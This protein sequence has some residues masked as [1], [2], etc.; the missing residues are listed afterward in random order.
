MPCLVILAM[1]P[2]MIHAMSH[3][4][5]ARDP[6]VCSFVC[7]FLC[8]R[9]SSLVCAPARDSMRICRG[10]FKGALSESWTTV[11]GQAPACTKT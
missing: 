1:S 7:K 9:L 3:S 4:V 10:P 5:G 8:P 6:L 11:H 2:P